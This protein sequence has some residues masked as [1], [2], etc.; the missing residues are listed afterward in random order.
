MPMNP[1]F[2]CCIGAELK[3]S[4]QQTTRMTQVYLY[5]AFED[6]TI[7]DMLSPGFFDAALGIIRKDDLLLLYSPNEATAKWTYARVSNVD[8]DGVTVAQIGIDATAVS[9]DTTGYSNI[10]GDNLQEIINSIDTA[11]SD[12]VKKDG[13]SIMSAPLKFVAGSLRGAIGP[14][15]GGVEFYTLNNDSPTYSLVALG[16]FTTSGLTPH[17]DNTLDIGTSVRSWK[18]AYI[19]RVITA[20]LN[21]GYDIAVPITSGPDTLAL[22]SQVDAA[23]NSGSQLYTTGV[24]YAKMYAGTTPPASAEIEGRNYADFSQTD[25]G[26]NPIIVIYTYTG[27][28]WTQTTT[29]TPPADYNGYM[30]I[31]SKIW[32]IQEQAGQQ[33]GLVLW[34]HNQGTFTPYP[35][36]VSFDGANITNST[37][38]GEATLSGDSTV[39]MPATPTGNSIVNVDYL[40]THNGTGRNVGD[41]FFTSRSDNELNGAVECN[42]GI[43]DGDDFTGSQSPVALME[44]G[45]LP[46][47]SL[48]QYATL[49]STNGSVGVFGWDGAGTTTFRVPSLTDIFVETGT[50]AQLGDFISEKLPN[51]TIKFA[52]LVN[53]G[54]TNEYGG[55]ISSTSLSDYTV[56]SSGQKGVYRTIYEGSLHS[57]NAKYEDDAPVQPKSVRYRV[58]V[59]LAISASDEAVLT[60]TAVTADVATLKSHE[61]IAFQAPTAGNNYTWYRKYADGWVE[62][63]GVTGAITVAGNSGTNTDVILPITMADTHYNIYTTRIN[64]GSGFAQTELNASVL[65]SASIRIN[66]WNNVSSSASAGSVSW[67]VKGMYAQ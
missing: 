4:T 20:V 16:R 29:I 53:G 25:S 27:G 34:S 21:N 36:I 35:R 28:A 18:D 19:V 49:L 45:K 14:S 30:T 40:A 48:S 58:M 56:Y 22:K 60:C 67:E 11:F 46:Y 26:G 44:A 55:I 41:I 50:A 38:Q 9:V 32:D 66:I 39:T 13:T 33:G 62:Q 65:T 2:L 63:G 42:G 8:R 6:D 24:W 57:G 43:Y 10:S 1:N 64:G 47:V 37:F 5:R 17:S 7:A 3:N 23:A 31:T 61:V 54:Q 52:A 12:Y 59:Q 51:A 15:F